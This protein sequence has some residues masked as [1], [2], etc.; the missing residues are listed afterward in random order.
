MAF[1]AFSL[2][3]DLNFHQNLQ[4]GALDQGRKVISSKVK[5]HLP[6]AFGN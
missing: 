1:A 2:V 3:G 6:Q 5:V 4:L